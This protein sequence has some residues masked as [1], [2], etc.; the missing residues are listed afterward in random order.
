MPTPVN[1]AASGTDGTYLWV[2]G[3]RGGGNWPQPGFDNVQR[4]D[5]ATGIWLDS[6]QPLSPLSSM[7]QG[8]GG[9]GRAVWHGERFFVLGGETSGGQVF[10]EVQV[11]SPESD[12]WSA[13][14]PLPSPRHGIYPVVDGNRIFVIGGGVL[15]G[16]SSSNITEV[17]QR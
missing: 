5:P 3:G 9:T 13:D 14:T 7:P 17:L 10:D 8:R 16:F 2:F 6:A 1:H 15:A 12:Q 4:F 11:Y